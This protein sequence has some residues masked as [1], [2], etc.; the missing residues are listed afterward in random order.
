MKAANCYDK[1][2]DSLLSGPKNRKY[3]L[4]HVGTGFAARVSEFNK[5]FGRILRITNFGGY[6]EIVRTGKVNVPHFLAYPGYHKTGKYMWPKKQKQVFGR[7]I[8]DL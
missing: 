4:K 7:R 5:V 8:D 2:F 6:Y 3:L 1:L